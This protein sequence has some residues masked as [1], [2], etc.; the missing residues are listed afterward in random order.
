MRKRLYLLLWSFVVF[1]YLVRVTYD[2]PDLVHGD[3]KFIILP[4]SI[5]EWG[6][7]IRDIFFYFLFALIPYLAFYRWY[8]QKRF[9]CAV[10]LIATC[11]PAIFLLRYWTGHLGTTRPLRLKT[12]FLNTLFYTLISAIYGTVFYFIRY[13]YSKDLRQKD[14]EIQS[15]QSE[16]SFL[17]SQINPHFLFNS[18]N[19]IYSLVY[20]GSGQALTAIAGLSDLLRYMLY[21]TTEKVPLEKEL[22]YIRKYIGLQKLR[23]DHDIRADVFVEGNVPEVSIAPLLL[24]PFVENAFKHGDFSGTTRGLT[25]TVHIGWNKTIFSCVNQKGMQQKDVGGGIGLDNVKRRLDLLYPDRHMLSIVEDAGR[26]V[27][28]LEL[29]NE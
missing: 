4:H 12:Y 2:M 1:Y 10:I 16:L 13:S 18:L 8:P 29:T 28:N 24:I 20:Q 27:V 19:N 5:V 26:F 7:R 14:L 6:A 11:L 22:D 9:H 21:D 15:R 17:R 23:F 3:P 25:V